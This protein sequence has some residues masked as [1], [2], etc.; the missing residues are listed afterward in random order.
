MVVACPLSF[1]MPVAGVPYYVQKGTCRLGDYQGIFF[2]SHLKIKETII[3]TAFV[4]GRI[5]L[6]LWTKNMNSTSN[7][8]SNPTPNPTLRV[9]EIM[10][11]HKTVQIETR[12]SLDGQKLLE[13][14]YAKNCSCA[15]VKL[16]SP[17][18]C[19]CSIVSFR[20]LL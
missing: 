12:L 13:F 8:T 20:T 11:L 4:F 1:V 16:S 15:L 19:T 3:S 10:R 17:D 2:E 14:F 6:G 9:I 7:P 5:G 18:Q